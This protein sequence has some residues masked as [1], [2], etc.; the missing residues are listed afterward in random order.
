MAIKGQY[1]YGT[2]ALT[3]G[4]KAV[5]G[6]GTEWASE[7]AQGNKLAVV[8]EG[9]YY[10]VDT[11]TDDTH[12]TLKTAYAGSTQAK[13]SYAIQRDFTQYT[14]YAL[15]TFGDVE[16]VALLRQALTVIDNQLAQV[17]PILSGL[18]DGTLQVSG[19]LEIDAL[20][21]D[22]PILPL[23]GSNLS[24]TTPASFAGFK[25]VRATNAGFFVW[26]ESQQAFVACT[27]NDDL[28]TKTLGTVIANTFKGT[29]V[30]T[31]DAR[32]KNIVG[33]IPAPLATVQKLQA[34]VYE[35][36][37]RG[38]AAGL[39]AGRKLLGFMAQDVQKVLPEVVTM[40]HKSFGIDYIMI[41]PLLVEAVKELASENAGLRNRIAAL[42]TSKP[43]SVVM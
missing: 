39:P 24:A 35:W 30:S 37:E 31:S 2:I 18:V 15:P 41:I 7:I 10:D 42:E 43:S 16:T 23:A 32:F 25:V 26:D 29:L 12:L 5:V 1:R 9:V 3:N 17:K 21:A 8:G 27:S 20:T 33:P 28:K 19:T 6:T 4:S 40:S 38:V 11:V 13:V 34:S 36:N 14:G 22:N